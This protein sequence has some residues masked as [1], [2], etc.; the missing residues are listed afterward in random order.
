M[1]KNVTRM[2]AIQGW[3]VVVTLVTL[4]SLAFGAAVTVGTG[5]VLLVLS[6][7][8]AVII[9]MLWPRPQPATAA[10]VLYGADRRG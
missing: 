5:A 8:P 4:G 9:V 3:F 6:V 10:E 1:L 2:R 7:V